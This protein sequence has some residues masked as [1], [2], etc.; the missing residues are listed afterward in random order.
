MVVSEKKVFCSYR[1]SAR[2]RKSTL[3]LSLKQRTKDRKQ[4]RSLLWWKAWKQDVTRHTAASMWLAHCGSAATVA[5][6]L[7]TKAEA[8]KFWSL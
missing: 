5:T 1:L 3:P 8:E 6:A 7:V 4:L 2:K